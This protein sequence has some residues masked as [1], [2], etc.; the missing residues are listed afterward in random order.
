MA[1]LLVLVGK[2][3]V[4]DLDTDRLAQ[5]SR[6]GVTDVSVLRD[7]AIVGVVLDGWAFDPQRSADEASALV[8]SA[9]RPQALLP[10]MHAAV[11]PAA[12]ERGLR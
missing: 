12:D 3:G 7:A 6:L 4:L 5:L 10:V 11:L 2:D 8:T 1:M 9:P